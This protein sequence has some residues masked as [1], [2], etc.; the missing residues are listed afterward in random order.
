M[1]RWAT[2]LPCHTILVEDSFVE[3][4]N[5]A[6]RLA[7]QGRLFIIMVRNDM[8]GKLLARASTQ[9]SQTTVDT[10]DGHYPTHHVYKHPKTGGKS[11]K[12]V[13]ILSH[14]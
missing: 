11:P 13:P 2:H 14:V 3:G 8:A 4:H 10:L 12:L 9:A 7:H 5:A 6:Q 1:C